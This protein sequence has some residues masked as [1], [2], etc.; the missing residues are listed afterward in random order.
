MILY[1]RTRTPS[2]LHLWAAGT[3][4]K[5]SAFGNY[6]P[7]VCRLPYNAMQMKMDVHTSRGWYR[8]LLMDC[9]YL[10]IIAASSAGF[11]YVTVPMK[12]YAAQ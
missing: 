2:P 1:V 4:I 9:Y 3:P 11:H 12:G 6:E 7:I 8:H 5:I 10:E